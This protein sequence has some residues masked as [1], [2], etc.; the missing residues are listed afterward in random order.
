M[1]SHQHSV[2]HDGPVLLHPDRKRHVVV[3]CPTPE[4]VEQEDRVGVAAG[5]QL[6]AAVAHQQSVAVVDG[7]SELDKERKLH[8]NPSR[9]IQTFFL[10]CVVKYH[11]QF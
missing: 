2:V 8:I 5:L 9:K 7:I 11:L 10:H 4:R 1:V 6:A 3:L